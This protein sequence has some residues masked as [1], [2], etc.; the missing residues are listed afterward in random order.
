MPIQ[1]L[2]QEGALEV[3]G[4]AMANPFG[5][6]GIVSDE[7]GN[8]GLLQLWTDFSVRGENRVLPTPAPSATGAVIPYEHRVTE[9]KC[10]L[11]LLVTG[12]V[13]GQTGAINTDAVTGLEVNL[14]YLMTNVILPPATA[15]GTRAAELTMPSGATRTAD[16]QSTGTT[17]QTYLLQDCW[18]LWIA[19]WHI[20]IPAGRFT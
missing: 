2:T 1:H 19:T 13:D 3:D 4:I 7:K 8:G 9:S 20:I 10:D 15:T 11:R 5:A 17:T 16:I 6:W 18:S 12:D 14:G